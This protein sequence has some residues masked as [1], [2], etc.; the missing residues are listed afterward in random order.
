VAGGSRARH[1]SIPGRV[2]A[3]ADERREV[4]PRHTRAQCALPRLLDT[5][6]ACTEARLR[7]AAH[8]VGSRIKVSRA[9]REHIFIRI[10]RVGEWHVRCVGH[11]RGRGCARA[12]E[13]CGTLLA[14]GV[15]CGSVTGGGAAQS[16]LARALYEARGVG[17]G[18]LERVDERCPLALAQR[19]LIVFG[20][21]QLIRAPPALAPRGV[22]RLAQRLCGGG[23]ALSV[24]LCQR[25]VLGAVGG[26]AGLG[27][28]EVNVID[29]V[30]CCSEVRSG[31]DR[32]QRDKLM[33]STSSR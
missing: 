20:T 28:R 7:V 19:A 23:V 16:V 26:D 10:A 33:S 24:E 4:K 9:Q 5:I 13:L 6:A 27:L 29:E 17:V 32:N 3:E 21:P 15:E 31:Q 18:V 30:E 1:D 14:R 11:G 25:G 22:L 2:E 12:Q 8:G